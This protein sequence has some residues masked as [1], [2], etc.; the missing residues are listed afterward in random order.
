MWNNTAIHEC[1]CAVTAECS[2]YCNSHSQ[3]TGLDC[4]GLGWLIIAISETAAAVNCCRRASFIMYKFS[5]LGHGIMI[6]RIIARLLHLRPQLV[7]QF[8]LFTTHGHNSMHNVIII[9]LSPN[10]AASVRHQCKSER[11]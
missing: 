1:V 10:N 3:G 6:T 7:A 8:P 5:Q 9:S 2:G 4:V 11:K